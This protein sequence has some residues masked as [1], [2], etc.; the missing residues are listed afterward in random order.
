MDVYSSK[1]YLR[2]ILFLV[3]FGFLL[4]LIG[5][6]FG[7][8]HLYF[9]D[10]MFFINPALRVGYRN[11][12]PGWFG[13][14]GQTVIY[15]L[16]YLFRLL[17]AFLLVF[18]PNQSFSLQAS[19]QN[20]I[21]LYHTLGRVVMAGFGSVSIALIFGIGKFW[22][23]RV[24]LMSSFFTASSFYLIEQSHIVRPDI[25]QSF[26]ILFIL[27]GLLRI[28][29]NPKKLFWYVLVGCSLGLAFTTKYPSAFLAIPVLFTALAAAYK[30]IFF[31]RRWFF[32]F[33][34][35]VVSVFVSAPYL[36]LSWR[37]VQHDLALENRADAINHDGLGFLQHIQWYGTHV[38]SW[39]MGT[40]LYIIALITILFFFLSPVLMRK[41]FS[42][43][44]STRYLQMM[45]VII[46]IVSY[47]L[48]ISTLKL[49][50]ERWMIPVLPPLYVIASLGCDTIISFLWKRSRGYVWVIVFGV[51]IFMAPFIR[52]L[53]LEYGLTHADTRDAAGAWIQAHIPIQSTIVMEPATPAL[54]ASEYV[55][56]KI[57]SLAQSTTEQYIKN[58]A[59]YFVIS[60]YVYGRILIEAARNGGKPQYQKALMRYNHVLTESMLL[61][62]ISVHR[63][64]T[65]DQLLYSNDLSILR[66]FDIRVQRGP[67]IGVYV[68]PSVGNKKIQ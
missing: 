50:W 60:E 51:I 44:H 53:R 3:I 29:E 23:V 4:R 55:I 25:V 56:Q 61:Q 54:D 2:L 59:G 47:I 64:F 35:F 20:H 41:H 36:F 10:E 62:K 57:P 8:P 22:K 39:Q 7:L 48:C 40:F 5:I 34:S 21:L 27:Y 37:T 52:L 17:Y 1:K 15:I 16:A 42:V 38:L 67:F 58:G 46:F 30:K 32:S 65:L 19:Y 12:N 14:P 18:S 9:D 66:T 33:I 45:I 11:W 43:L 13:A 31:F 26:F 49:H 6:H 63:Q 68:L 28:L 24:G